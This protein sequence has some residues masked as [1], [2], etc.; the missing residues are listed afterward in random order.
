[1]TARKNSVFI[2]S[3][4][5]GAG[6]STLVELLLSQNKELFFSI[7]HTT[8]PPRPGE[9][10]GVEYFFV[11]DENFRKMIQDDEFF[12]WAQVHSYYYG[13]SKTMLE[14]AENRRS[15]LILDIDVQGAMKVKQILP[16]A[17][18]IFILPPSFE[19]LRERLQRRQ[20]DTE[21]QIAKRIE[22]ARQEIQYCHQYDYIVINRELH[23]AFEDLSSI[24]R[25]Q[26][27]LREN[28]YDE[29]ATIIK[30]FEV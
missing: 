4:P 27:C 19:V 20:K 17:T 12:E 10:N 2:I 25:S 23:A 18:S 21:Q 22:N 24:I 28:L 16:D 7:S 8:R 1:M 15:D 5:S 11:S 3:A 6:K 9:M 30:S 26:G 29:V 14:K 13:T